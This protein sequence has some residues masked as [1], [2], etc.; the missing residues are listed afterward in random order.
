VARSAQMMM[1]A[2]VEAGHG[3]PISMTAAVIPALRHSP[4][5]LAKQMGAS[6]HLQDRYDPAIHLP[7]RTKDGALMGMG[8]TEK[9][10]GSD[11]RSNTTT[12]KPD[13]GP[14]GI[15]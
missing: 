14:T 6:L 13:D 10:G 15:G 7:S 1:M 9:Q 3:C 8:M 11:V 2:G 12:A 4:L 5:E